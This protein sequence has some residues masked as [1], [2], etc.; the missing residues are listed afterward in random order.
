MNIFRAMNEKNR[1]A[2]EVSRLQT[3]IVRENSRRK[4]NPSKIDVKE[5]AKQYEDKLLELIKVKSAIAQANKDNYV[6]IFTL[7]ELKSKMTW[8]DTIPTKEGIHSESSMYGTA[9]Q[10]I[11]YIAQ[12]TEQ[13][14]D[15]L[16]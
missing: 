13:D 4:E 6:N 12:I 7:G 8:L 10:N 1:L 16:K 3:I 5:V 9:P 14:K 15:T 11:E 2:G